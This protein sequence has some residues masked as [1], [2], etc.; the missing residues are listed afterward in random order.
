M[1]LRPVVAALLVAN[2]ALWAA[3]FELGKDS[4]Q[5]KALT[6]RAFL[7]LAR[8]ERFELPTARFVGLNDKSNFLIN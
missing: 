3:Q 6:R 8:P 4:K 7:C 5:R 2:A 1:G